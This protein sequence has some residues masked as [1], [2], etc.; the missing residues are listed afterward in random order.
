[1]AKSLIFGSVNLLFVEIGFAQEDFKV[2][3][4]FKEEEWR[5]QS[6]Y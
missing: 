6:V 2:D 5:Q 1:M 4:R 3:P